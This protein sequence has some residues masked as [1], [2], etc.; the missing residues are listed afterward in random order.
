MSR[1][2]KLAITS[3]LEIGFVSI[4]AAWTAVALYIL[5]AVRIGLSAPI[6]GSM[7][8]YMIYRVLYSDPNHL[9]PG[10][11]DIPMTALW[12]FLLFKCIQFIRRS[13]ASLRT[14]S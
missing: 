5:V 4:A 6:G 3:G 14:D 13:K 2:S 9:Y 1:I 11:L 8:A 10:K 7:P 12:A